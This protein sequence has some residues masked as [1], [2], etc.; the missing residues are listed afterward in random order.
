MKALAVTEAAGTPQQRNPFVVARIIIP[1][2]SGVPLLADLAAMRDA[3]KSVGIDPGL[4]QPK[5]NVD[6]IID[7]LGAGRF[8]GNAGC[9]RKES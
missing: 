2:S 3:A 1:D 9:A 4:I 5:V 6:L 8:L 7:H